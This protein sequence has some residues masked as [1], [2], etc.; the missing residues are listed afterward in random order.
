MIILVKPV[1]LCISFTVE[2]TN[3]ACYDV[4]I[5]DHFYIFCCFV[6]DIPTSSPTMDPTVEP[7]VDPTIEPTNEPTQEPTLLPTDVPSLEPTDVPTDLPTE[8]PSLDPT[9][10]PTT[11]QPSEIPTKYPTSTPSERPSISPSK[12][13]EG[14]LVAETPTTA[15]MIDPIGEKD[16]YGI[17]IW[18]GVMAGLC[19]ICI[20][21]IFIIV[22]Y[23]E[24]NKQVRTTER[25]ISTEMGVAKGVQAKPMSNGEFNTV[26]S[27]S[28]R[29][30]NSDVQIVALDGGMKEG[31]DD[32]KRFATND[33]EELFESGSDSDDVLTLG[34]GVTAGR[35]KSETSGGDTINGQDQRDRVKS[36]DSEALYGNSK[37]VNSSATKG[38]DHTKDSSKGAKFNKHVSTDS[39]AMYVNNG[40]DAYDSPMG[41]DDEKQD[42]MNEPD[43]DRILSADAEALYIK[44]K[45]TPNELITRGN[46][47]NSKTSSADGD[48]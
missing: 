47:H 38:I 48:I 13:G 31:R 11:M 21:C 26:D 36:T 42:E 30:P 10:E 12:F 1:Q 9:S 22:R 23:K 14:G 28:P 2:Q 40:H 16:D 24:R 5:S 45:T 39:E 41:N 8:I 17:Y 20:V 37:S 35:L 34:S 33:T 44:Q 3:I 46:V 32:L 4:Y 19:C 7:T 25:M 6:T 27:Q 15:M 18:I 43:F 29:S